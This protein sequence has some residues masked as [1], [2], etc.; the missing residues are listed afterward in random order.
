MD[1]RALLDRLAA[2]P[3]GARVLRALIDPDAEGKAARKRGPRIDGPIPGAAF[4][5]DTLADLRCGRPPTRIDVCS[6][7]APD[8]LAS[9]LKARMRVDGNVRTL[10][11]AVVLPT[12]IGG[13]EVRAVPM[14]GAAPARRP[15]QEPALTARAATL[16]IDGD[17]HDPS[18]D[19]AAGRLRLIDP[20]VLGRRPEALVV[21]ARLAAR[22][23]LTV[24]DETST[25]A[26][27]ARR[28]GAPGRAPRAHIGPH[29]R[30]LFAAPE[31]AEALTWLEGLAPDVPL[32][33]G[34]SVDADRIAAAI[35]REPYRRTHAI[36]RALAPDA[37]N[38]RLVA[39]A[40]GAKLV[41]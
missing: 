9:E 19:L 14:P 12:G 33:D 32:A 13:V 35:A 2:D 17:L 37:K 6:A 34:V 15:L 38:E 22:P 40:R 27:A 8:E 39:F 1:G 5:G 20:D 10:L 41:R 7:L 21:L 30:D 24:T 28:A 31:V 25:A 26:I 18:G 29:L 23:E 11:G 16:T 3:H 36:L 4:T